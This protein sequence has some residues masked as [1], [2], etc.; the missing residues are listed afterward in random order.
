MIMRNK[1][2]LGLASTILASWLGLATPATAAFCSDMSGV[3]DKG[4][5]G[6]KDLRESNDRDTGLWYSKLTLT[7]ADGCRVGETAGDYSFGCTWVYGPGQQQQAI[8]SARTLSAGI[9]SCL[10]DKASPDSLDWSGPAER[11]QDGNFVD[12]VVW[13][14]HIVFQ[15]S[16]LDV[17][18]FVANHQILGEPSREKTS[19]VMTVR[20]RKTPG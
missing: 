11:S 1:A 6:W 9:R 20:Y 8:D 7:G 4:I 16:R 2:A 10:A 12:T 14:H 15:E 18:V 5:V 13:R 19:V 3:Y 17:S